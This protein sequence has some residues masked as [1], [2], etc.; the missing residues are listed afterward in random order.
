MKKPDRKFETRIVAYVDPVHP[1]KS[2]RNM[3]DEVA[4]LLRA[5]WV[6]EIRPLVAPTAPRKR[7]R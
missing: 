7:K 1:R 4:A 6:V 3:A 5:G 2:W